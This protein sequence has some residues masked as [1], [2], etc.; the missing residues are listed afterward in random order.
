MLSEIYTY[1]DSKEEGRKRSLWEQ[2]I[3]STTKEMKRA[4]GPEKN[5]HS[6]TINS[7]EKSTKQHLGNNVMLSSMDLEDRKKIAENKLQHTHLFNHALK[8]LQQPVKERNHAA[9]GI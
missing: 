4:F 2:D 9:Q 5:P 7:I 1:H 8:N 6:F 3:K